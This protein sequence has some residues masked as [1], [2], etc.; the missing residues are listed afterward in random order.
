MSHC[1]RCDSLLTDFEATRK[2]GDTGS[3]FDL[4]NLCFSPIAGEVRA[5]ERYDLFSDQDRQ[6]IDEL[7]YDSDDETYADEPYVEEEDSGD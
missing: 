1:R 5:V 4:C 6:E 2:D 3:Y 7:N